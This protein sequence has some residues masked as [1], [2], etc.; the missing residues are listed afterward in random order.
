MSQ[1]LAYRAGLNYLAGG[2]PSQEVVNLVRWRGQFY[3]WR[4]GCYRPASEEQI[5]ASFVRWLARNP[6]SRGKSDNI[7]PVTKAFVRDGMLAIRAEM[8]VPD[9]LEPGTWIK[10]QPEGT[11]G[12]FLAAPDGILD[13]ARLGELDTKLIPTNPDFFTLT[14]LPVT[15]DR[16]AGCPHWT[17]FLEETF[18]GDMEAIQTIQEAV[19]YCLW[20]D[21][22]FET[23]FVLFGPGNTGKST[24]AETIQA[25]LGKD[26]LGSIPLE[27]FGERFAL[28]ALVGKLANIVFDSS[29][30][31]R[32]AEGTLKA[33]VSGEP[34]A[35]E[36]KHSP[37]TTMRLSAKHIFITNILPRFHDTTDGIWRRLVLL[38]FETVCPPGQRAA[39]L[40]AKLRTEL[41]G[42]ASWALEGLARL[43]NQGG[44]TTSERG[45]VLTTEYREESNQVGLFLAADCVAAPAGRVG[46]R[47]LYAHYR[48]WAVDNGHAP[49]SSTKF[50]REVRAL[51]PQP[52][53]EVREERGGDRAF[54]G[55]QL[56][57]TAD[58]VQQFRVLAIPP[59]TK[60]EGL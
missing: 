52:P 51:Y 57:E 19:G 29:E 4:Q 38:P 6:G 17:T 36:Q 7:R 31:D 49:L 13:L 41:P 28:S 11:V 3:L 35:V 37:V 40:K 42:I 43:L 34:V 59:C 27:R 58:I 45:R 53:G 30:I 15:P 22:R 24:L 56:R 23:F 8:S 39:G 25:M 26:N 32:A 50:Y 55:L 20:P 12:P 16:D 47:T 33:L 10:G 1:G 9:N 54:V 21:C 14:A 46:R 44:F 5:E 18:P 60:A 48:G 2:V